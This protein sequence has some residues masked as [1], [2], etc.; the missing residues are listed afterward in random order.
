ARTHWSRS[1]KLE[2]RTVCRYERLILVSSL[3]AWCF[4]GQ[5]TI[6]GKMGFRG[7]SIVPLFR[8]RKDRVS[9]RIRFPGTNKRFSLTSCPGESGRWHCLTYTPVFATSHS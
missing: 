5:L 9:S 3:F 8:S 7:L 1:L 4:G 2:R 6:G